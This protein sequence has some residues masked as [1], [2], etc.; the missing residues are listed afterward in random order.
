MG[1]A[2]FPQS[3][4]S[5]HCQCTMYR[6]VGYNRLKAESTDFEGFS[7]IIPRENKGDNRDRMRL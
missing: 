5:S 7:G 4:F 1:S 6:N 2:V 3:E